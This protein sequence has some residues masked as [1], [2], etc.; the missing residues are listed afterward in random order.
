MDVDRYGRLVMLCYA[1]K[2]DIAAAL[3]R[4]GMALAYQQYSKLYI[5]DETLPKKLRRACGVAHLLSH[6]HG[7]APNK[8]MHK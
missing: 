5:Q 1:G 6:G 8:Y 4:D 7:D 3:V 2:L